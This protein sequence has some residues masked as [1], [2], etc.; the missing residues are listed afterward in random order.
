[1]STLRA[2]SQSVRRR[3]LY[4]SC[5][6]SDIGSCVSAC[7]STDSSGSDRLEAELVKVKAQLDRSNGVIA[8]EVGVVL[9]AIIAKVID[10]AA[11]DKEKKIYNRYSK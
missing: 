6:L 8:T 10:A 9:D 1:M 7:R 4:L 3:L 2:Q 11:L 5:G